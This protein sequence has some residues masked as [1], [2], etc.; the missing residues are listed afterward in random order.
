MGPVT[1]RFHDPEGTVLVRPVDAVTGDLLAGRAGTRLAWKEHGRGEDPEDG[2]EALVEKTPGWLRVW[3][4]DPA[5]IRDVR[6]VVPGYFPSPAPEGGWK[7]RTV[8]RLDADPGAVRGRIVALE[9]I[10]IDAALL[11]AEDGRPCEADSLAGLPVRPGP[12]ALSGIPPGGWDLVVK[13]DTG[14]FHPDMT[15]WATARID[16]RGAGLDLGEVEWKT[17]GVLRARLLGKD[18]KPETEAPLHLARGFPG[19]IPLLGYGLSRGAPSVHVSWPEHSWQ[20]ESRESIPGEEGWVEF[21][22]LRPGG[23]CLVAT[24]RV[25]GLTRSVTIPLERGDPVIVELDAA[26]P[27]TTC[28]LR[29]TVNGEEPRFWRLLAGPAFAD[30]FSTGKGTLEAEIPPGRHLFVGTTVVEEGEARTSFW[31]EVEIP[32]SGRFEGTVDLRAPGK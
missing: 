19:E 30:A 25:P 18:G 15:V 7:G 13:G 32:D 14:S 5:A 11:S 21:G 31:A 12:F 20:T 4:V 27:T 9:N 26:A 22:G 24:G 28:R 29:F 10:H 23:T 3:E 6:L 17:G 16:Y 1:L 2:H 8:V